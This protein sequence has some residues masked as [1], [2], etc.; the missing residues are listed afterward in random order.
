M[1]KASHNKGLWRC[2]RTSIK[3]INYAFLLVFF[4][5]YLFSQQLLIDVIKRKCGQTL[6]LGLGQIRYSQIVILLVYNKRE[7]ACD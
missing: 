4:I 3:T 7:K 2:S 5:L 1:S 6:G